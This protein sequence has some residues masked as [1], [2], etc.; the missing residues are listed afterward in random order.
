MM[1]HRV[2]SNTRHYGRSHGRQIRTHFGFP[3]Q[4]RGTSTWAGTWSGVATTSNFPS[5]SISLDWPLEI[6]QT[7]R[8]QTTRHQIGELSILVANVYGYPRGPTWPRAAKL[9]DTLL[10]HIITNLVIGY[11]GYAAIVGDMN[12]DPLELDQM[13]AWQAYGWV[14]A[15]T[16]A[17]HRWQQEPMPTCKGTTE[18]DQVWLSPALAA[19]CNQVQVLPTF[20]DHR[21]VSV[22]FTST[23]SSL[24]PGHHP[25]LGS[26]S[27]LPT[28][29]HNQTSSSMTSNPTPQPLCNTSGNTLR[30]P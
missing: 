28:G 6:W 29:S 22:G 16:L 20:A 24:G 7:S 8:V 3:A 13:K 19:L 21:T 1:E 17:W 25:F 4:L 2:R 15:Q 23:L 9:T 27:T 18:R 26:K 11:S 14:S 30:T 5:N 12:F 10:S